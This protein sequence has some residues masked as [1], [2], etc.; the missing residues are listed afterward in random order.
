MIGMKEIEY[1]YCVGCGAMVPAEQAREIFRTGFF[2]VVQP[3]G[4]CE[5]CMG[6]EPDEENRITLVI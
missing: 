2:R 4:C 3:L 5:E 6:D 1:F